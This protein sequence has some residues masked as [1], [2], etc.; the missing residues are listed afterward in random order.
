MLSAWY[1]GRSFR[2]QLARYG[3]GDALAEDEHE[4]GSVTAAGGEAPLVGCGDLRADGESES[5]AFI[6]THG[7]APESLEQLRKLVRRDSRA[8]VADVETM[9]IDRHR[10]DSAGRGVLNGVLDKILEEH[11]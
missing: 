5:R 11:E 3:G 7:A 1:D 10:D 6:V 4:F 9:G 8:L 2:E